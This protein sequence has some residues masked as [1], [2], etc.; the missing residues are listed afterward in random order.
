MGPP[1]GFFRD[2]LLQGLGSREACRRHQPGRVTV[3]SSTVTRPGCAIAGEAQI[4]KQNAPSYAGA[5]S[6]S[7]AVRSSL[8]PFATVSKLEYAFVNAAA[9]SVSIAD[10]IDVIDAR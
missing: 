9:F 4:C 2:V 5:Q 3:R 1:A 8:P 6:V 10:C 7:N